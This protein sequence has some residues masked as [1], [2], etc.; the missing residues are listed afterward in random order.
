MRGHVFDVL[1]A[2]SAGVRVKWT[3]TVCVRNYFSYAKTIETK[4]GQQEHFFLECS[5]FR[6]SRLN[7]SAS[8]RSP[9]LMILSFNRIYSEIDAM[10]QHRT[11]IVCICNVY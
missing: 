1:C 5:A 6:P 11:I 8:T 9:A 3:R 2:C 4:N 10:R 7:F